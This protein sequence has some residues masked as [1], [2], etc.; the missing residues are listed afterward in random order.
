[1]Q[2]YWGSRRLQVEQDNS[3]DRPQSCSQQSSALTDQSGQMCI[4]SLHHAM[5]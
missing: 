1:M 4:Q 5:T 3:S 2:P